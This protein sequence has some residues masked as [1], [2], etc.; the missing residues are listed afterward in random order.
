MQTMGCSGLERGSTRETKGRF[1]EKNGERE[2]EVRVVNHGIYLEEFVKSREIFQS[3][4][5]Q[6]AKV[7]EFVLGLP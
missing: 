6:A 3:E 4:E 1:T 2:R 7:L 5:K